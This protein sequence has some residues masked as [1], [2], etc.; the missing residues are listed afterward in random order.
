ML[1]ILIWRFQIESIKDIGIQRF[2]MEPIDDLE[3]RGSGWN[4]SMILVGIQSFQMEPIDNLEFRS[5]LT[6]E[7]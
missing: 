3:F 2:W 4:L 6:S 1:L 5:M 7:S